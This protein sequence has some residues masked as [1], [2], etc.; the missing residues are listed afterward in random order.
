[1]EAV[2]W[3]AFVAIRSPIS[4]SAPRRSLSSLPARLPRRCVNFRFSIAH[5]LF[6]RSR[7]SEQFSRETVGLVMRQ[8]A[9]AAA[10][11][12]GTPDQ[13][14]PQVRGMHI[15]NRPRRCGH[16]HAFNNLHVVRR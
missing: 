16:W 14:G 11:G 5:T 13:C 10:G 7:F 8:S 1:M 12:D 4:R 6:P 15:A 9:R 2:R 3:V